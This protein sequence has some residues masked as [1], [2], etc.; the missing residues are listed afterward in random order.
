MSGHVSF[1]QTLD[2]ATE[3]DLVFVDGDHSKEGAM[4][5]FLLVKDKACLIAFHDIVNFK[6]TGAIEAWNELKENDGDDFEF[7]EFIDQYDELLARQ[8]NR[9]LSGIGVAVKKS[10]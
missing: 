6:T 4:S 9:K 2:P 7:F 1:Y 8:P 5:D 3:L 10:A